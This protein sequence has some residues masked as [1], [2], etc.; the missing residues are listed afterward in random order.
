MYKPVTRG[1]GSVENKESGVRLCVKVA[2]HVS[3]SCVR[4]KRK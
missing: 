2:G 3:K 4:G 1:A